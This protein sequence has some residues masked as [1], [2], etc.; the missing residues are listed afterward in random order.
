MIFATGRVGNTEASGSRTAGVETDDRGSDRRRRP[1]PHDRGGHLRRGRRDRPARAGVG[2]DGAGPGRGVLGLRPPAQGGRRPAGSLRRLL[3]PRGRD[4]RPHRGGGG[5]PTARLRRR[6]GAASRPTPGAAISGGVEGMVKLVFARDDPDAPRRA[7]PRA[8]RATELV[9]QGQ[10]VI[11]FGGTIDYF[12][13]STFNV[14]TLSEAYKYAAY[15]GLRPGRRVAPSRRQ[16]APDGSSGSRRVKSSAM[17]AISAS[18]L[19]AARRPRS[20]ASAYSSEMASASSAG[21]PASVSPS[22]SSA[23]ETN[24]MPEESSTSAWAA[25]SLLTAALS[26][27]PVR[28]EV[29][30]AGDQ[31]GA[32]QRGADRGAEVGDACSAGRRS[33]RSAR[34]APTTP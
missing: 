28:N 24:G 17:S 4:G 15:D 20:R 5:R 23:S 10:A 2:V 22:S 34:R 21:T 31:D 19:M 25:S 14:P 27:T 33:R 8:R 13:H 16:E 12:I 3:H 9:H 26:S 11:H 29:V 30:S 32:G 18:T 1:L 7:H 6:S